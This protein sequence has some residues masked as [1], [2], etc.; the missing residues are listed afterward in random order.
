M[1]K[2]KIGIL[3]YGNLGKGVEA[4]IRHNKDME[5][6][7]IVTR[8]DPSSVKRA[9]AQVPVFHIGSLESMEHEIDVLILCGGS[10]TDLPEQAPKFAGMFNTVDAFDTHARVT[11]Y[12]DS[13][14]EKAKNGDKISVIATGWDP[15]IFSFCRLLAKAV[16]PKGNS[17]TFW[18]PGVSQGHS[19]AIRRIKGVKDARQYTIPIEAAAEKARKGNG[20]TLTTR[21]KHLRR[22]FVVAERGANLDRIEEEIKSMPNYFADYIT[23]VHFIDKEELER[24]HKGMAHGGFVIRNGATGLQNEHRQLMEF[25]LQLDSNPEFTANVMLAYARAAYRMN[26]EGYRGAMTVFDIAPKYLF[27]KPEDEI[28][29]TLL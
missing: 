22:C 19:D 8:R 4:G 5:L 2:I 27:Q 13:V 11:E 6:V 26:R 23:E 21:D 28:R 25:R 18:G 10:R 15:G 20:D 7:A 29:R 3:G 16:L 17:S 14:D 24:N 9:S 1:E 12:F